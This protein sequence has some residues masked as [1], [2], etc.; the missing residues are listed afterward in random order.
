MNY[1]MIPTINGM[2]LSDLFEMSLSVLSFLAQ[3]RMIAIG[4][5]EAKI[6]EITSRTMNFP[7]SNPFGPNDNVRQIMKNKGM[8]IIGGFVIV[9]IL[10]AIF[11]LFILIL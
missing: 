8:Q 7:E 5:M 9:E 10:L 1:E 3:K 2:N 6:S 11:N 4:N